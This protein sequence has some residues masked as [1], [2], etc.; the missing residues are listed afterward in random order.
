V[1]RHAFLFSDHL[2]VAKKATKKRYDVKLVLNLFD[3]D[4]RVD[5]DSLCML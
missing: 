4:V 2:I 3:K 5:P 1:K